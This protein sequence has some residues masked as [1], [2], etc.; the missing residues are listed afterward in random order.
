MQNNT[1]ETLIGAVVVIVAAVFLYFTYTATS[2]GSI[3]GYIIKARF[4]AVDGISVGTD[5]KV[6][7]IKVGSVESMSLDPKSYM[8]IAN[9]TIR[10]DIKIP[11]D[12][13]AKITSSSLLGSSYISIS[14]GG[15]DTMLAPGGELNDTQG[16]ID[17]M[18][19]VGRYI[20]SGGSSNSSQ[21]PS[22]APQQPSQA[23]SGP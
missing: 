15:S 17:L 10:K 20:N 7:G 12:S 19:L 5:V 13:S 14:P 8:A 21:K 9:L 22:T 18:G 11:D 4:A 16:A 23:P 3:S 1:V 2:Q 6:H